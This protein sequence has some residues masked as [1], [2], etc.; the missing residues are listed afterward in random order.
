MPVGVAVADEDAVR[1]G[2]AGVHHTLGDPLVV[3]VRDLLAQVVVLQQGRAALPRLQRV[4]GVA[5]PQT[6]G[7]RQERALLGHVGRRGVGL[8]TGRRTPVGAGLVG[9]GR[10]RALRLGRLLEAGR[11]GRRGARDGGGVVAPGQRGERRLGGSG[12]GLLGGLDDGSGDLAGV[13][14]VVSSVRGWRHR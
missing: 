3:E 10:Q 13:G 1:A 8:G 9:L 4:V 7:R 5:Q 14:H 12:D 2:S 11:L 6:L